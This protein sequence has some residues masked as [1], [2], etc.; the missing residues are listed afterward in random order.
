MHILIE[1]VS[2]SCTVVLVG[3]VHIAMRVLN[4]AVIA[5]QPAG[6]SGVGIE[7]GCIVL[8]RIVHNA[9]HLPG[10]AVRVV[11]CA[12]WPVDRR[13]IRPLVDLALIP[14]C[15]IRSIHPASL[16]HGSSP[17]LA[18]RVSTDGSR[19]EWRIASYRDVAEW[20]PRLQL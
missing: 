13:Y 6:H 1:N 7:E 12:G 18:E 20:R 15:V 14:A 8:R 4:V 5:A 10:N 2:L 17:R 9:H 11:L 19:S 16:L 3:R